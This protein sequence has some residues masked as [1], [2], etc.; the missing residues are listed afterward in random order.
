ML[1]KFRFSLLGLMIFTAVVALGFHWFRPMSFSG[2]RDEAVKHGLLV[3]RPFEIV[4][5]NSILK[6]IA[7]RHPTRGFQA[8]GLL[9]CRLKPKT[10]CME[11]KSRYQLP[12][13][14]S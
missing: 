9:T 13:T 2:P 3:T 5:D 10:V 8:S 1:R 7:Q 6:F 4:A 12:L 14:T 11:Y